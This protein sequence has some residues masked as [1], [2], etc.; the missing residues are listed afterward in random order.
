VNITTACEPVV[1]DHDCHYRR[2]KAKVRAE[3]GE[4]VLRAVH[5]EPWDNGPNEDMA[6]DHAAD[7]GKVLWEKT[8]EVT[9]DG[10]SVA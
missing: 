7:D 2:D 1:H 8:V 4:E 10:Y 6:E 9:T 3:E 5:Q